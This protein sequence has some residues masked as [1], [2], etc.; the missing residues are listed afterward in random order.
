MSQ[1][2]IRKNYYGLDIAKFICAVMIISS[3]FAA[4]RGHFPPKIDVM[5]SIYIFAVPFFFTCSAFLFFKKL[6]ALSDKESQY[7]Y[8]KM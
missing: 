1:N 8:F 5:F 6:N 3:H 2:V 7:T 4:E